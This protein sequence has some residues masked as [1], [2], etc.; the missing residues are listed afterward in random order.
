M[1]PPWKKWARSSRQDAGAT[2]LRG[3]SL[4]KST[5]LT[6]EASA[7]TPT[8]Q[9]SSAFARLLETSAESASAEAS[10]SLLG[11]ARSIGVA[12]QSSTASL[13]LSAFSCPGRRAGLGPPLYCQNESF[14]DCGSIVSTKGSAIC[15]STGASSGARSLAAASVATAK[16]PHGSMPPG[17]SFF[18]AKACSEAQSVKGVPSLLDLRSALTSLAA[19]GA[20]P[21]SPTGCG[22]VG[23]AN[24]MSR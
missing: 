16:Q 9:P 4:P 8:M 3:T 13:W 14:L 10:P 1:V 5:T 17:S 7:P 6:G 11:T 15:R 24:T 12:H 2:E 18:T 19:A 20:S 23:A 22:G 21:S